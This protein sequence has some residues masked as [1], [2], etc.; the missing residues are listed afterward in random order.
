MT[1]RAKFQVKSITKEKHWDVT[2]GHIHTVK[3]IPVVSG[4]PENDSFF[5]ATPCGDI[6]LGVVNAETGSQ[7]ELGAE[8][9]VDFT[10]A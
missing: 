7:F 8:Y 6:S 2:K 10:P 4:S 3:L 5:T 9:Y 1:V